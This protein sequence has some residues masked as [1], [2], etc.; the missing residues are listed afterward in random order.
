MENLHV[1]L[2]D[3]DEKKEYIFTAIEKTY[4]Y[5]VD[6]SN[7]MILEKEWDN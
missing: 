6:A 7:G 3:S 4:K 1:R 2:N 5:C